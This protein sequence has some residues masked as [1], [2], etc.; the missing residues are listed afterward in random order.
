MDLLADLQLQRDLNEAV[1]AHQAPLRPLPF[2]YRY[3]RRT[4]G[5]F[6]EEMSDREF[7]INFR[8]FLICWW[9]I[10]RLVALLNSTLV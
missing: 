3:R 4:A 8:F 5:N 2:P 10:E 6:F 1:A 7:T 9:V